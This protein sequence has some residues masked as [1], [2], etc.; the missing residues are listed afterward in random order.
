MSK[1]Y[2]K[3]NTRLFASFR[4]K[5]E[6]DARLRDLFDKIPKKYKADLWLWVG[7]YESTISEG[8]SDE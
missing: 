3:N 5:E 6:M 2:N 8:F 7:Q 1:K 4:N